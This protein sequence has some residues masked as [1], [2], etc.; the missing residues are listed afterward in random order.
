VINTSKTARW[1]LITTALAAAL[2]AMAFADYRCGTPEQLTNAEV[3][4]CE[5]AQQDSPAALIRFVNRTKAI[6]NLYADDYASPGDEARWEL[7][8]RRGAQ[9]PAAIAKAKSDAK[10]VLNAH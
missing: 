3:R 4:A 2:S 1:I 10:D 6:Y 5:L 9:D 7:T 8:Q